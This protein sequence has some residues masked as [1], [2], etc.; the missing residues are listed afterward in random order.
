MWIEGKNI[1]HYVIFHHILVN[2]LVIFHYTLKRFLVLITVETAIRIA[3]SKARKDY[4]K[5]VEIFVKEME[6]SFQFFVNCKFY[7]C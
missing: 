6:E 1:I 7:F 2:L 4:V 5:L 3:V